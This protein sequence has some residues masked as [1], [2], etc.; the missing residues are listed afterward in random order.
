MNKEC[1]RAIYYHI[2]LWTILLILTGATRVNA[3]GFSGGI[4][5]K[6]AFPDG[7][8]NR[9]VK[10][11]GLGI[12]G[13]FGVF[14]PN[15]P[16][17]LGT[18]FSYLRYGHESRKEPFSP[19]IPDVTVD[20]ETSNNIVTGHL[21]IR[22]QPR[23][24]IYRPYF[25][26][27][28]GFNYLFT[29]TSVDDEDDTGEDIASTTNFDDF[30]ASYGLGGGLQ[31]RVFHKMIDDDKPFGVFIDLGVRYMK[32][33]ESEYLKEGSLRV[34]NDKVFMDVTKSKTD[35]VTFKIGTVVMF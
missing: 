4:N 29:E 7:E 21:F 19:T 2:T 31:I 3:F 15:T 22:L 33:G 30:V 12:S 16:V 5:F 23:S 25:D 13:Q 32:G 27:L 14:L 18:E 24:G 26:G 20:V 35:L 34:V 8:F 10:N 17:M 9:H 28:F 6:T 1:I 11:A